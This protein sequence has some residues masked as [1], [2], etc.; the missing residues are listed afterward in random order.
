MYT[1]NPHPFPSLPPSFIRVYLAFFL[2]GARGFATGV[3]QAVYVYTPEVYPTKIRGSA[4]GLMSSAA[5]IGGL[6]TPF[7]AQVCL[8]SMCG[9]YLLVFAFSFPADVVPCT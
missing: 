3:F 7:I 8:I 6:V 5:R 9:R 1:S 4:L 2:F